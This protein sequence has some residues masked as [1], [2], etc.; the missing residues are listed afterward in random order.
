MTIEHWELNIGQMLL[1]IFCIGV[2][3]Q[4]FVGYFCGSS[5]AHCGRV[6]RRTYSAREAEARVSWAL[7]QKS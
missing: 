6:P 3:P 1:G 5:D 7:A 2:K 4:P